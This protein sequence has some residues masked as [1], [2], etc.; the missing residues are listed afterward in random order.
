[1]RV[2][3]DWRDRLPPPSDAEQARLDELPTADDASRLCCQLR[4]TADLDGLEV[5]LQPDSIAA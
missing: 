2:A 1:V 5:D 4:M 3:D